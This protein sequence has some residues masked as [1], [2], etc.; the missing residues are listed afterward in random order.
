MDEAQNSPATPPVEAP[1]EDVAAPAAPEP[2][3][4]TECVCAAPQ[5]E[6]PWHPLTFWFLDSTL[7]LAAVWVLVKTKS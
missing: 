5:Y 4:V 2:A 1:Q 6:Y 3:A 7:I